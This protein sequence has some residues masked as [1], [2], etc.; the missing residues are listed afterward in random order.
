MFAEMQHMVGNGRIRKAYGLARLL[1]RQPDLSSEHAEAVV[2][3]YEQRLTDMFDR[4]HGREAAEVLRGLIEQ[5]P[6]WEDLLCETT[7]IRAALDSRIPGPLLDYPASTRMAQAID[8]FVRSDLRDIRKLAVHPGLPDEHPLKAPALAVVRAW[9]EVEKSGGRGASYEGM[10]RMVGRRSP[11]LGWRL[12]VQALASFYEGNDE[13]TRQFLQRVACCDGV[14]PMAEILTTLAEGGTPASSAGREIQRRAHGVNLRDELR[15][16]DELIDERRWRE[17]AATMETLMGR[18]EMRT[19]PGLRSDAGGLFLARCF[20]VDEERDPPP[21]VMDWIRSPQDGLDHLMRAM[22][23]EGE[24]EVQEW[25]D[26]LLRGHSRLSS[27]EK[28]L[29]CNRMAELAQMG[30][31]LGPFSD[32]MFGDADDE[33]R[34]EIDVA[35]EEYWRRSVSLHPM[36]GTYRRWLEYV[37][38]DARSAE[39]ILEE[40]HR[41]FPDDIT[42]LVGL[43]DSCRARNVYQKAM[44]FFRRLDELAGGQPAVEAVR[45]FLLAD[46]AVRH[47]AK[48]RDLKA[49][50]LLDAIPDTASPFLIALRDTLRLAAAGHDPSEADQVKSRL[51][52]LRQPLSVRCIRHLLL[53]RGVSLPDGAALDEVGRQMEDADLVVGNL[54]MLA[55]VADPLWNPVPIASQQPELTA[56][57]LRAEVDS[58]VLRDCLLGLLDLNKLDGNIAVAPL[59]AL[60]ARGIVRDDRYLSTFLAYRAFLLRCADPVARPF[61]PVE[62]CA[63]YRRLAGCLTVG[64][65][66]AAD[67]GSLE[68]V[69]LVEL[70][71]DKIGVFDFRGQAESLSRTEVERVIAKEGKS[72]SP[73]DLPQP[74][75][76]RVFGRPRGRRRKPGGARGPSRAAR[77]RAGG[78][79]AN[80]AEDTQLALF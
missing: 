18:A 11:L 71:A 69:Q 48:G 36:A 35:P 47:I 62:E 5:R 53:S 79:A 17:A 6:G 27:I 51:A 64:L 8:A 61:I 28:A 67:R 38:F 73:R 44:S 66:T 65:K 29:I 21:T 16:I 32:A 43:V 23:L 10:L 52:A 74:G 33:D 57:V 19:R 50:G 31:A 9:E 60:T 30:H 15:H 20:E 26:Y 14:R 1:L 58:S 24:D 59:W 12:F 4:G 39:K 76:R 7:I 13:V 78:A 46:N 41:D 55:E 2:R 25:R 54:R 22:F 72:T 70:V 3:V 42:P 34:E 77:N 49:R 56:A 75:K 37:K 63:Y 40:W 80:A 68:D 45:Y